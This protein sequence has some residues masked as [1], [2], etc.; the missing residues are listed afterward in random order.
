MCL[1]NKLTQSQGTF[2]II[3]IIPSMS[4]LFYTVKNAF[5]QMISFYIVTRLKEVS[6]LFPAFLKKYSDTFHY[7]IFR[8]R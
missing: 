4:I 7:N 3:I 1:L 2:V 5:K 6:I 8:E